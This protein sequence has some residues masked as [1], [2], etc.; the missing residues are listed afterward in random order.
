MIEERKMSKNEDDLIKTS[1]VTKLQN[2]FR[3]KRAIN[4]FA[5]EY[6]KKL[7]EERKVGRPRKPRNPVG[8]PKGSLK[9]SN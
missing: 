8:R 3:N 9:T 7:I 1:A 2:S 6:A 4:E 5:T